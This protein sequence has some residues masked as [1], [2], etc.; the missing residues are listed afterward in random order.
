M[1]LPFAHMCVTR[2]NVTAKVIINA[3]IN[4]YALAVKPTLESCMPV[5][6]EDL[7]P[8]LEIRRKSRI[9]V[10]YRAQSREP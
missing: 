7:T 4:S 10:I 8:K 2:M 1:V 3:K 5:L 6:E 9:A